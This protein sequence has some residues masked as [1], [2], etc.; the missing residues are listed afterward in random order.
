MVLPDSTCILPYIMKKI[1]N[2]LG[3]GLFYTAAVSIESLAPFILAPVLTH[4]L[5]VFDYGVWALFQATCAFLRPLLGL[6][7]DDF[8]RIRHHRH[9]RESMIGYLIAIIGLS[10]LVALAI[11]A[12]TILFAAPVSQLL[13]FPEHWLWAIILCSWLHAIFYMLLAYYQFESRKSRFALI[14]F[15]QATVTLSASILL[16]MAGWGWSGAVLGKIAGLFCGSLMAWLWIARLFPG[17]ILS[18]VKPGLFRELYA[19]SWR[20][21]PSGML[22]VVI[23]FTDRLLLANLR[24]V[25]DTS[26]F[27]VASLFPMA[28]M[29]VIQGYI[30]GWQPW[31]FKRL[32]RREPGD[33][34]EMAG[35]AGL[36]FIA[37]PIG[38]FIL[39]WGANWLGPYVI[40]AQ[41]K[42]A[43]AY[44][45]PLSMAMV[46]QGFYYF[47]QTILQFYQRLSTLSWIALFTML[48][49][50]G[51]NFTLIERYGTLGSCWATVIAYSLAFCLTALAALNILRK[52]YLPTLPKESARV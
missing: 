52:E 35:G 40:D 31:C 36:F 4:Y 2:L 37:L 28:L 5:S 8:V 7:L 42:G 50:F 19:F 22:F 33:L 26:L 17:G 46:A 9:S 14:H 32:A 25:Q 47:T 44:V 10:G 24:D 29:I 12:L 16:V 21:L 18:Y 23:V 49:N 6:T 11:C 20:Y 43:F 38:G 34:A 1:V 48:A 41:Y 3:H 27:S 39:S 51:L 15:I 45:F 30:F 13:H